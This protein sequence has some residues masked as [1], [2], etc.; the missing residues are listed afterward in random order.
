VIKE[1]PEKILK[2]EDLTMEIQRMW[3]VKPGTSNNRDNWNCLKVTQTVTQQHTAQARNQGSTANSH[4]GH[5]TRTA[6]TADVKYRTYLT[7]VITLHVAQS[8]NTEQ[9]QRCVP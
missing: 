4:I 7:C 5:R 9:W 6:G 3:N 1:E 8:V 2:C